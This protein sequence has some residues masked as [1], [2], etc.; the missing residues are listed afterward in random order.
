[1][2]KKSAKPSLRELA[3]APLSG[4]RKKEVFVP[5]WG[6]TVTV[7]EPSAAGWLEWRQLFELPDDE[8]DQPNPDTEQ[9]NSKEAALPLTAAQQANRNL[10]SDVILFIDILLDEDLKPVFT[11]ADKEKVEA[12]YGPVHSRLL[13]QALDLGRSEDIEKKSEP[14][15]PSS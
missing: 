5:D 15:E 4:F 1:M 11:L 3:L 12:I 14:Q 2:T 10:K 8:G 13:R 6:V 7:R 9:E